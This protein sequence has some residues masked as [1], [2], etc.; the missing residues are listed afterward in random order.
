MYFWQIPDPKFEKKKG[1]RYGGEWL[2]TAH[3]IFR[4]N[5]RNR[6]L[7][8]G[9]YVYQVDE[10]GEFYNQVWLVDFLVLKF[11]FFELRRK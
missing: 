3:D 4:E 1:V 9:K 5:R 8:G 2:R 6:N 10:E 7:N 11:W